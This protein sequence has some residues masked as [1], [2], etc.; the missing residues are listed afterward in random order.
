MVGD[1]ELHANFIE[2]DNYLDSFVCFTNTIL[3]KY[4]KYEVTKPKDSFKIWFTDLMGNLI[5]VQQFVLELMLE[6]WSKNEWSKMTENI[7]IFAF[8]K[9][10][11]M[12]QCHSVTDH[13]YIFNGHTAKRHIF[14]QN[15]W[16]VV[17]E[18]EFLSVFDKN[19]WFYVF[20]VESMNSS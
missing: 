19:I 5:D 16:F 3:T 8:L 12:S 10:S 1:V 7:N 17:N 13:Y 11:Q 9:V 18:R 4:K 20:S 2:R 6:F 15:T 14:D